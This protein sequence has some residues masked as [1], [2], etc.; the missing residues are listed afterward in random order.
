MLVTLYL[1]ELIPAGVIAVEITTIAAY[2]AGA[3][4]NSSR[5]SAAWNHKRQEVER[6]WLE[7][8]ADRSGSL[9]RHEVENVLFKMR[10]KA[11]EVHID[12]AMAALTSPDGNFIFLC[13]S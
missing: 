13:L 6:V 12:R 4:T 2:G 11:F 3:R 8:D 1:K 9:D 5:I 7:V 10:R